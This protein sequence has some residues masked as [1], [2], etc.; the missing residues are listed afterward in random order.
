[1]SRPEKVTARPWRPL[2]GVSVARAVAAPVASTSAI[3]ASVWTFGASTSSEPV[4]SPSAV[5]VTAP[6]MRF[7]AMVRSMSGRLRPPPAATSARAVPASGWPANVPP[8]VSVPCQPSSSGAPST[9]TEA[10]ATG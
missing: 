3:A 10:S 7:S 4:N 6:V 5:W 8:S 2:S 1:M 9:R